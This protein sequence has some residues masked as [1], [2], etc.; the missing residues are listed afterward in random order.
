M[1][2]FSIIIPVYNVEAYLR[3]CIDSVLSQ[4]FVDYE[5]ILVDDGSPDRSGEICD[6]YA[7]RDSRI[8]VIHKPNGGLSDARNHGI[9]NA[10]GDYILF[11]DSDDFWPSEENLANIAQEIDNTSPNAVIYSANKLLKHGKIIPFRGNYFNAKGMSSKEIVSLLIDTGNFPCASW[12]ICVQRC[13]II[14]NDILFPKGVTAEDFIWILKILRY[15]RTIA[16][17]NNATILYNKT[18]ETSITSHPSPKGS[19]GAHLAIEYWK[20][21]TKE[22]WPDN[23]T[24]IISKICTLELIHFSSLSSDDKI[25]V[26][27]FTK[28]DC[29]V[30]REIGGF[31][32]IT[33]WLSIKLLGLSITSNIL[34]NFYKLWKTIH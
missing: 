26:H 16:L 13:M 14:N 4:T 21:T 8:K 5:I 15:S 28:S 19:M 6:E 9:K 29:S 33:L 34:K 22:F 30:L 10:C 12:T 18:N 23:I 32:N 27:D 17:C 11:I 20:Q 31:K 24:S 1:P 3:Q 7:C 25:V 2:L